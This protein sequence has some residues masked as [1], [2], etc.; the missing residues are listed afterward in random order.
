MQFREPVWPERSQPPLPGRALYESPDLAESCLTNLDERQARQALIL[1]ARTSAEH[2]AARRLLEPALFRFYEVIAGIDAPRDTMIAIANAIP[3][4]SFALAEAHAA[5]VGRILTT[6]AW[7]TAQRAAWLVTSSSLLSALGR[8]EEAPAAIEEAVTIRREL[9]VAR[10]DAFRPDLAG[11]L[12]NQSAFLSDLGRREE[13]L[14][15]IEE[16][17][18][19][20]RELAVARPDAFRPDLAASLNNLVDALEAVGQAAEANSVRTEAAEIAES[21]E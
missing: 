5:V 1:L 12:N 2:A 8:R 13:A 16:A 17:V 7:G 10:P 9:A 14:A 11:S 6:Y 18:T 19:I 15:A 20:R 4:P 3:Y 21:D